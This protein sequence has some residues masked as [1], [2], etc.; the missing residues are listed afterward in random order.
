MN[1]AVERTESVEERM[2]C[3]TDNTKQS[4]ALFISFCK[5]E[6]E[7]LAHSQNEIRPLFVR[8][9][10]RQEVKYYNKFIVGFARDMNWKGK[11]NFHETKKVP[12][13]FTCLKKAVCGSDEV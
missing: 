9:I 6:E 13:L 3:V 8:W 1:L 11:D 7:H 10:K 2:A 12:E 5:L 4:G